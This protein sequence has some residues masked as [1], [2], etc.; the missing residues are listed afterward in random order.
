MVNFNKNKRETLKR[1]FFFLN[2]N[3]TLPVFL[4]ASGYMHRLRKLSC[5][6]FISL[7]FSVIF[8]REKN[9]TLCL[10][11]WWCLPAVWQWHWVPVWDWSVW[12]QFRDTP[13]VLRGN[14]SVTNVNSLAIKPIKPKLP[15][16]LLQ[17]SCILCRV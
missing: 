5:F 10:P 16:G 13:C 7:L 14:G 9:L 12:T 4:Q 6:S 11:Q 2:Q 3:Q 15:I 17:C 8:P 1:I